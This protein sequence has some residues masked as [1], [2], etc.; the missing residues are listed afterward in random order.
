[1]LFGTAAEIS[2][3]AIPT[4]LAL[5]G[6]GAAVF[7]IAD[8][9]RRRRA[10]AGMPENLSLADEPSDPRRVCHYEGLVFYREGPITEG[11]DPARGRWLVF[12]A[13]CGG[14][15]YVV[16]RPFR[17][18]RLTCRGCGFATT[19]P[20]HPGDILVEC[21]SAYR[22]EAKAEPPGG[23]GD[24]GEHDDGEEPR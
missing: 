22:P 24:E 15:I 9:L 14:V 12:C 8:A 11:E 7:L 20:R 19:S 1:M 17:G 10:E 13:E 5:A 16:R 23:S 6:V 3:F 4:L 2:E 18:W 21:L